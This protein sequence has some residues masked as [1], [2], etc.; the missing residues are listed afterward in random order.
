MKVKSLSRVQLFATPWTAAHKAPLSM[1]SPGK[2]TGVGCHFPHQGIITHP[3]IKPMPPA[4]AGR[5]FTTKP[6][7]KS[8][9][10]G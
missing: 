2:N 5:C 1:D 6:P 4:L 7:G 9:D 8:I 3:G 10:T